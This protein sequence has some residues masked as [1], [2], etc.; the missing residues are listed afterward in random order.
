MLYYGSAVVNS[1]E[2]NNATTGK[3]A[4]HALDTMVGTRAHVTTRVCAN[5]N[6]PVDGGLP[7][8]ND[9][10]QGSRGRHQHRARDGAGAGLL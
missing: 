4:T 10:P 6:V 5:P 8:R 2:M 7:C 9:H 3:E 1:Q